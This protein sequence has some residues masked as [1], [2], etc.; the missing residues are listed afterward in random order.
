MIL[1]LPFLVFAL[2]TV[3]AY[4]SAGRRRQLGTILMLLA[5]AWSLALLAGPSAA[6]WA[7]G[8][9]LASLILRRPPKRVRS[10][11]EVL[12]RR[13]V[14]IGALV[15][16]ALILASRF[17]IGENPLLL[18]AVPWFVGAIGAAWVLNPI[19]AAERLQGQV[20]MVGATGALLLAAMPA[21]I[22]TAA[23]AG[24]AAIL[25]L[26]GERA[27]VPSAWRPLLSSLMLL[28]AGVAALVAAIGP[29][30][31]RQDLFDVSINLGGQTLFACAVVLVAGA[32][33]APVGREWAALV[34]VAAL[35]AVAPSLRF[36]ALAA[37]IAVAT[38]L[39]RTGERPAWI[40]LAA[41]AAVPVLQALAP[42]A[43]S[44]RAQAAA[45]GIG[46]VV[47]LYAA[48]VG[49]LRVLVLPASAFIVLAAV[50][51]LS[52]GN[53]TRFEWVAA[54]G[55]LMLIAI[56]VILRLEQGGGPAVII[57]DRL[58]AGLL[59][60]AI[61]VR[62]PLGLGALA[63]A[64]IAVDLAIVRLDDVPS[65][66]SR[67]LNRLVRLARSS[68]PPSVTFAAATLAVIAALQA[69]LALGLLA[70]IL[71]AALQLAPMVD[72]LQVAPAPERPWSRMRWL[73]SALGLLVGI[74]PAL[75]LRM[76][77]L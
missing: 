46:L 19:D 16:L 20:L 3:I 31:G 65:S 56:V 68:W 12:S 35:I 61:G 36:A 52:A 64:L 69:S 60:V 67:F 48:R 66:G 29:P 76:L 42:P 34:A 49:M 27:R 11:F 28:A 4:G 40:A 2:G 1:Y 72:H 51:A 71:W 73:G 75:V 22:V 54:A 23:A 32:L 58:L 17:S 6:A 57:G 18:T 50:D 33:L 5:A 55:A 53:L 13:A 7:I 47:M 37:L 63:M 24:A 77:R 21:G 38:A 14:T 44:A 41:L 59:L 25:P 45:L 74:A 15:V 70:A 10:T 30:V 39:E 8:P 9:V 43:W 26:L 62:D